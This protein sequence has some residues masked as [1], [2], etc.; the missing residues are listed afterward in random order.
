MLELMA[1]RGEKLRVISN[2]MRHL[3]ADLSSVTVSVREVYQRWLEIEELIR[4][5][6]D[7][8][9]F[10]RRVT[11]FDDLPAIPAGT[12][13][14][15]ILRFDAETDEVRKVFGVLLEGELEYRF[16]LEEADGARRPLDHK[17]FLDMLVDEMEDKYIE[18]LEGTRA[19]TAN[20]DAYIKR[21][22]TSLD[23]DFNTQFYYP[24]FRKV[25]E[26]SQMWDVQMGQVETTTVL[27]NN[28]AFAKV[29]PQ[30]TMEFDLPKRDILIAEAMDGAKAMVQDFG[31][32]AQDPTFPGYGQVGERAAH[33]DAIGRRFRWPVNRTKRVARNVNRFRRIGDESTRSR[34]FAVRR[35][36][37]RLEFPT[38]RS[39][40]SRRVRA[41]R[42]GR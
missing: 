28:R 24:T 31:A 21:L 14:L 34:R 13:V 35:C 41:G 16:A 8:R 9:T 7:D 40:N 6:N 3:A 2:E 39:T 42:S 25:R 26:A 20:L 1:M 12:A 30:A 33:S 38:R 18:L 32:L 10:R 5:L 22:M 37:G 36:A 23:D 27:A 17:K 4:R 15:P 11:G 29:S 19:H